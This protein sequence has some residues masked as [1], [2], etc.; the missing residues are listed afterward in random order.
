M[1]KRLLIALTALVM[2][3]NAQAQCSICTKT[4]ADLD[5]KSAHGLNGGILYLAFI[6]LGLIGTVGLLWWRYR[7]VNK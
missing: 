5:P 1:R 3:V 6:P 4:A 2:S 7:P